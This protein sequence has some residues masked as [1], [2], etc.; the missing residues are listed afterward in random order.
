MDNVSVIG[1][2]AM[3]SALASQLVDSGYRVNIWNRTASKGDALQSRGAI[4]MPSFADAILASNFIVVCVDCYD[5]FKQ[6]LADNENELNHKLSGKT[7]IQLSTGTPSEARF[8]EAYLTSRKANYLDGVLFCYPSLI[9]KPGSE[10]LMSGHQ[11][12]YE[13]S[14]PVLKCLVDGITYLGQNIAASAAV[15][16]GALSV[17]LGQYMGVAHGAQICKSEGVD[18]SLLAN[19]LKHAVRCKQMAEIIHANAYE[20]NSLHEGASLKVWNGVVD[21]MLKHAD[22]TKSNAQFPE[23]LTQIYQKA[24]DQGYGEE[25]R[26]AIVKVLLD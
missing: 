19:A 22:E 9:G 1:L 3:G 21:R 11:Q 26:A 16:L 7:F 2:G 5:S 8:C 14:Y 12:S 17:S 18:I 13:S 15:D 4:A 25:D 20:L 23:F 10:M 24:V 6:L